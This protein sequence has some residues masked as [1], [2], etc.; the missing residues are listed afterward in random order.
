MRSMWRKDVP[1]QFDPVSRRRL[2]RLSTVYALD[3][4]TEDLTVE[5]APAVE[6]LR[7]GRLAGYHRLEA[8]QLPSILSFQKVLPDRLRFTR[9]SIRCAGGAL[10]LWRAAHRD[11]LGVLTLEFDA[12]PLD[13]IPAAEDGYYADIHVDGHPLQE[14]F[15]GMLGTANETP[16]AL[17]T[18]KYQLF[19]LGG[20][21]L[22]GARRA[23]L[24]Q[25][26]VYRA[27]LPADP[28]Y[29]AIK[30]PFE[31][32]RRP[33]SSAAVGPYVSVLIRQQDYVENVCLLSAIQVVAALTRLRQT[34]RT[35]FKAIAAL[36]QVRRRNLLASDL[37]QQLGEMAERVSGLELE[38][39]FG[40][41]A[42]HDYSLLV[43]SLRL[44]EFHRTL[45]EESNLDRRTRSTSAMVA[46]LSRALGQ[47]LAAADSTEARRLE[48]RRRMLTAGAGFI[49]FVAIPLGIVFGF[50][51]MGVPEV[52][53]AT[54][55][56]DLQHYAG[57]YAFVG[58]V[59][60]AGGIVALWSWLGLTPKLLNLGLSTRPRR[61]I[62]RPYGAAGRLRC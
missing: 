53:P 2:V 57:L 35:A 21:R 34:R 22:R 7:L 61:S 60:L 8:D 23:D 50:F 12:A 33:A 14:A 15:S 11:L 46:R 48:R 9:S 38:L 24:I 52:D 30:Y 55:M 17:G 3:G 29:T 18:D 28:R 56:F 41:E 40:V 49:S 4:P 25:R 26:L 44:D 36:S 62:P 32:N 59:L 58:G 27:D 10:W 16:I 47:E 20:L 39:S 13:C 45:C 43:P 19:F 6:R 31:L 42:V 51:G 54:S 5:P 37:R 1:P